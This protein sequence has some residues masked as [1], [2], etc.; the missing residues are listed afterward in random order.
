MA[1]IRIVALALIQHETH[2]FAYEGYDSMK[3]SHFYRLVGGGVKFGES[4]EHAILREVK[5][6]INQDLQNVEFVGAIENIFV[7]RGKPSHEIC[8]IYRAQFVDSTL[9]DPSVTLIGQE[10][11]DDTF[12]ARWYELSYFDDTRPLYPAGLQRLLSTQ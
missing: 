9:Y 11:D 2:L 1:K 10:G 6:E 12:T 3:A 8:L 7:H 5:E 4:G